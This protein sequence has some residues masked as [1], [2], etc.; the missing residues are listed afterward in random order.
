MFKKL[1]VFL[2]IIVKLQSINVVFVCD[3]NYAHILA[4]SIKSILENKAPTDKLFIYVIHPDFTEN[5][6]NKLELMTGNEAKLQFIK[7]NID[8]LKNAPRN[9]HIMCYAKILLPKLLP[10]IAKILYIDVDTIIL[11]SLQPIW[12]TDM[13]TLYVAAVQNQFNEETL[14]NNHPASSSG[15][16]KN[17][18]KFFNSGVML[19]NLEKIREDGMDQ[20]L[21]H[22]MLEEKHYPG[23]QPIFNYVLNRRL[24][25]LPPKWNA[26]S[27]LF[28]SK[29]Y[30]SSHLISNDEDLL[31]ATQDPCI[32]HFSGNEYKNDFHFFKYLFLS[33]MYKTPWRN[34]AFK[35]HKQISAITVVNVVDRT[36]MLKFLFIKLRIMWEYFLYLLGFSV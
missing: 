16:Y 36:N 15:K 1:F 3:N 7:F 2:L 24:I 8:A 21:T 27:N 4:T 25:Y 10:N 29:E 35:M 20:R 5:N 17:P 14:I 19:L 31:E 9:Y 13:T 6:I 28:T 23:D 34:I 26:Q 32:V 33:Y 12:D 22:E 18:D 11:K 30:D